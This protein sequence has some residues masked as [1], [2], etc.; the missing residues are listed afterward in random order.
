RSGSWLPSSP[1]R[2]RSCSRQLLTAANC[3]LACA[4]PTI[5]P[6]KGDLAMRP[7]RTPVLACLFGLALIPAAARPATAQVIDFED[8]KLAPESFYNG[9]DLAG[10]FVS[11][12]A[13][14]NNNYNPTFGSWS[15]W[16]Y[17][18]ITDVTTPGFMNQYSAYNLPDGGGDA[19]L[20]YG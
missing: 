16:S 5:F 12:G 6:E 8:L 14:F 17:S 19:S 18:N 10:G 13:F 4:F 7:A 15:G 1:A 11:E 9:S 2:G 3:R 20:N